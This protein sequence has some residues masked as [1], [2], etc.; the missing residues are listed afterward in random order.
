MA[1]DGFHGCSMGSDI[2]V[3]IEAVA[4]TGNPGA[5]DFVLFGSNVNGISWIGDLLIGRD[6]GTGNPFQYADT[7]NVIGAKTVKE[8]SK[9]VLTRYVPML[10]DCRVIV[11]HEVAAIGKLVEIIIPDGAGR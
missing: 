4:T 10:V 5:V 3:V 11:V 8:A 7:V 6:S 9:F 1:F 2:T